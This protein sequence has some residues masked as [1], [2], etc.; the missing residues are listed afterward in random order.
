MFVDG[1]TCNCCGEEECDC[2]EKR[3]DEAVDVTANNLVGLGGVDWLLYIADVVYLMFYFAG[4]VVDHGAG[5][6][7][8]VFCG[9]ADR[10][11]A[12]PLPLEYHGLLIR[13][14]IGWGC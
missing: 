12:P 1:D 10:H 8:Y 3:D 9:I 13:C 4:Y 14:R 2:H 7:L 11:P 6:L 5:F